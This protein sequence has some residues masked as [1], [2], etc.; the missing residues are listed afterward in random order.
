MP[1]WI[2]LDWPSLIPSLRHP[3]RVVR[4]NQLLMQGVKCSLPLIS[5]VGCAS[6]PQYGVMSY[7]H[8]NG[9]VEY[10]V[11]QIPS[12][13][14]YASDSTTTIYTDAY[15]AQI[16]SSTTSGNRTIYRDAKGANIGSAIKQ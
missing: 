16:G 12:N 5:L 1:L 11:Y 8:S 2:D 3:P 13:P 15:G 14:G 9:K 10:F 6:Q 7:T 4:I